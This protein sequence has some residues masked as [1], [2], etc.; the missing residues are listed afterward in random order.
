ME[1]LF[2]V[3]LF[4][5]SA[6]D[7]DGGFH[8]MVQNYYGKTLETS[9]DLKTNACSA[10][11][12]PQPET[13]REALKKVPDEVLAKYYGCG[14]PLPFGMDGLTVVD[15]GS[16]SGRDCYVAAQLVG[17]HG[18]VIGVDMT[19]EQLDV[20]CR[21]SETFCI[22][23]LGYKAS[24]LRFVKGFIEMLPE[25]LEPDSVDIIISNCTVNLSPNK[26]KVL[27]GAYDVL[28]EGGEF[29]F[30]DM[31]CDRRR[32][33]EIQQHEVAVG[34]GLGGALYTEDFRRI[35]QQV[36]F[37]DP[38]ILSV[39]EIKVAD[40]ALQHLVGNAKFYSIT[41]RLFKQ[42]NLE[43]TCEDYGQVAV[44]KGSISEHPHYYDLDERH[45]FYTDKPMLVSGNS[46]CMVGDSWLEKHFHVIGD[47]ST[48]FG[49]FD[50]SPVQ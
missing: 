32:S 43:D 36:G 21:H 45:R 34:E 23:T 17:E 11:S 12:A 16:G 50:R 27:S 28:K 15:L 1:R 8:G 33:A 44:Y 48:H 7:E 4:G 46:A 41:Y 13:I 31:Y 3:R 20:A 37:V 29:Y 9:S 14:N 38:R 47:R 49:R 6:K 26:H 10:N 35:A 5:A 25:Y 39:S 18:Q 40:K 2:P 24:N 22:D 19:D 42:R 30:S